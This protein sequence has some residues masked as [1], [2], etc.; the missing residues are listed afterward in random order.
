LAGA[1]GKTAWSKL[2]KEAQAQAD[3]F[4]KEEGLYIGPTFG[5]SKDET[6]ENSLQKARERYA[7]FYLE[8]EK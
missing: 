5:G 3:R 4:I 2:P 1:G 6:I 8:N 7:A